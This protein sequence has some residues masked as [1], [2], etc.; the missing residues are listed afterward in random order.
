MKYQSILAAMLGVALI[1]SVMA[2]TSCT[3]VPCK[4]GDVVTTYSDGSDIYFACPSRELS[5]YTAVVLGLISMHLQVTGKAPILNATTGEPQYKD[6]TQQILDAHRT[7]AGVK[8]FKEAKSRCF[9]GQASRKVRIE[10]FASTSKSM[11]VLDKSGKK[12]WM[13]K[14]HADHRQ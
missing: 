7:A 5:E 2:Q 4:V 11:L 12:Y 10:E 13:S 3:Q 14:S 9:V 6:E 1:G 8:S